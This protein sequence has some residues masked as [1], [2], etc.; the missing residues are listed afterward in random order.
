MK[1][2]QP[3]NSIFKNN[4]KHILPWNSGL[5]AELNDIISQSVQAINSEVEQRCTGYPNSKHQLFSTE[6][7]WAARVDL[8]GYLK[9]EISLKF[10]DHT[11]LLTA[12]NESRG[13]KALRLSLGDEVETTGISAKLENGILEIVL[14]KKETPTNESQDIEIL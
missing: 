8:P 5:F 14:P 2:N 7:G 12:R 6:T 11:L 3:T 1:E 9:E 4:M 10:E 13:E